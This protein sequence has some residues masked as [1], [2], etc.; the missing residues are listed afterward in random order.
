VIA[1]RDEADWRALCRATGRADWAADPRFAD[2]PA[3]LRHRA[4]LDRAIGEWTAGRDKHEAM[5]LLQ[6]AAVP[7][8]A[9]LNGK[10]VLLD[11]H[12]RARGYFE[13]IDQPGA[14]RRPFP[15]CLGARFGAFD[16]SARRPAP[17]LGQHNREILRDLLGLDGDEISQLEAARVLGTAPPPPPDGEAEVRRRLAFPLDRLLAQGALAAVEPDYREQL[18]LL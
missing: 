18:G 3:R 8:G 1:C 6:A 13:V 4:D 5:H 2:L 11:P 15:R 16:T 7:A 9:V 12:L 17:A 10:E 14:G